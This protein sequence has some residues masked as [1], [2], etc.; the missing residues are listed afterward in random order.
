MRNG[1]AQHGRHQPP[2][3]ARAHPRHHD[4]DQ[5]RIAKPSGCY[6]TA[7]EFAARARRNEPGMPL[8]EEP[9]PSRAKRSRQ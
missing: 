1:H 8:D 7:Q 6:L 5:P 2:A 9:P 3:H 4:D